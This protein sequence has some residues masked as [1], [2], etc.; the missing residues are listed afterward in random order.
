M[1][2][3]NNSETKVNLLRA[4]AGESQARNRYTFAASAAKKAN[5]HIVEAVFTFTA[6]QEK[7]HAEIFYK[8]LIKGGS[9][10]ITIDAAYPVDAGD[11][12]LTLLEQARHNEF[13]EYEIVYPDFANVAANEGFDEIARHF[14]EIAN[15]EKVHGERFGE[16]AQM[17]KEDNLFISDVQT[18]WMCL[19]CGHVL[20]STQA[21]PICPVCSHDQGYFI[22]LTMAPFTDLR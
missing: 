21:P 4:F 22:R 6:D 14:R 17:I 2:D 18:G 10:N 8:H 19:N 3:F 1:V 16:F 9:Q 20:E 5:L 15:I 13:E 7:E 12:P 11:D